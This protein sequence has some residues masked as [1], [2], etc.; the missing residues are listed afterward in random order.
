[1]FEKEPPKDSPLFELDNILFT[2]HTAGIDR[3]S[4]EDMAA[5]AARRS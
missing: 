2:A 4:R 1:M 5:V 3:K